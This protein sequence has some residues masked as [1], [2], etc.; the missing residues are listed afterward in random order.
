MLKR[1]KKLLPCRLV[2]NLPDTDF[3][4]G[5]S[6]QALNKESAWW[7]PIIVTDGSTRGVFQS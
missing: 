5:I 1:S 7:E 4:K 3:K 2:L 6:K